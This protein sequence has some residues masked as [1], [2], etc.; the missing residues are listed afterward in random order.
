LCLVIQALKVSIKQ[1]L[2][3]LNEV[4]WDFVIEF[5]IKNQKTSG[6]G[7]K[8]DERTGVEVVNLR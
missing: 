4:M 1:K 6:I 2:S 5:I 7:I 3:I 8:V